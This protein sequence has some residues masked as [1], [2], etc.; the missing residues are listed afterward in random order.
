MFLSSFDTETHL[1]GPG[2]LA[3]KMVCGSFSWVHQDN[4]IADALLLPSDGIAQLVDHLER[5]AIITG[6][7]IAYDFGVVLANV[8]PAHYVRLRDLIFAAYDQGRIWDV[9]IAEALFAIAQGHLGRNPYTGEAVK[10]YSLEVV[11]KLVLGR[12]DAKE[13]DEWRLRYAELDGLPIAQWPPTAKRYPID[14]TRNVLEVTLKQMARSKDPSIAHNN[15]D[16]PAQ[17][18][19]AWAMHL[20]ALWGFRVDQDQV[21][22]YERAVVETREN[23]F[24]EL[25]RL[26]FLKADGKRD[27]SAIKRAVIRAYADDVPS[28]SYCQGTG[29]VE[30]EPE[31]GKS[32]KLLK[33]KTLK[34]KACVGLG[35]D[36]TKRK[37][38]MSLAGAVST[39]RDA[40]HESADPD[41]LKLAA[42]GET[43]KA[44]QTYIPFL[45][46][47]GDTPLALRPNA[48]LETGRASYDGVIQQF[49][50]A[51][52]ERECIVPRAGNVFYSVDYTGLELATH[53][54]SCLWLLGKSRLAEALNAGAKPHDM[55][56]ATLYGKT[57]AEFAVL[58]KAGDKRAKALRQAAKPA[59]F[60]FP[61]GMGGVRLALNQRQQG[62]DTVAPD[63]T[64]YHGLRFCILMGYATR[65]GVQKRTEHLG[66]PISPLC[67]ECIKAAE[68][69]R[70]AWFKQWPENR[71]YF[72]FIKYKT[73]DDP[74]YIKQHFSNRIR[75]RVDF[76]NAANG[77]FQALAADGAKRA[78]YRVVREQYTDRSSVIYGSR[79][80][81]FA[82]DE[83]V[84]EISR[85]VMSAGVE[86]IAALMVEEMRGVCPD[87]VIEAEP[88]LMPRWY[89][90]AEL[91]RDAAGNVIPWE[92]KTKG[93]K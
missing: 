23:L 7:N 77:Y 51:G 65:C 89:K 37:I 68:A 59:N 66:K 11:V 76:T 25:Y 73:Q 34:C 26:G 87:V 92:P 74:N 39:A 81:L 71:E 50:R 19:A 72:Q 67:V 83:L 40:L 17:C 21:N 38:P 60:G 31:V 63:G 88:T 45:R 1:I 24:G 30:A 28:C 64:V 5:G 12:A 42:F 4:A 20:G 22:R 47:A 32:G 80:I 52:K 29:F 56:A 53:A 61:G 58:Y 18:R 55:L 79:T 93:D 13:N 62:P 48:L 69:L 78:L 82:H 36:T 41:L 27:M 85:S 16:V 6:A 44:I 43:D 86:R 70:E 2:M 9:Q 49:P 54:Q 8:A 35:L 75:G 15:H 90:Q 46:D 14:D 57:D 84:G 3:P 91:V 33:T 10:R